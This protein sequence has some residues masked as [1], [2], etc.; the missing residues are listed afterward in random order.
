MHTRDALDIKEEALLVITI[1][2]YGAVLFLRGRCDCWRL[3]GADARRTRPRWFSELKHQ[4]FLQSYCIYAVPVFP[5]F[6]F[7]LAVIDTFETRHTGSA[8]SAAT[9]CESII[10]LP[11]LYSPLLLQQNKNSIKEKPPAF[12]N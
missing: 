7:S 11:P 6:V 4:L 2:G 10:G 12:R 5:D 9:T 3:P 8:D 1:E